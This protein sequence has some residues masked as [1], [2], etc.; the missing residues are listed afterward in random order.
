VRE[1]EEEKKGPFVSMTLKDFMGDSANFDPFS[2]DVTTSSSIKL[3][4]QQQ[5]QQQQQQQEQEQEQEQQQEQQLANRYKMLKMRKN[6]EQEIVKTEEF[7]VQSLNLCITRYVQPMNKDAKKVGLQTKLDLSSKMFSS[8]LVIAR[9]HNVLLPELKATAAEPNIGPDFFGTALVQVFEKFLDFLKL[10]STFINNYPKTIALLNSLRDNRKFQKFLEQTRSSDP[11]GQTLVS[12]LIMPVQRIPRYVLLFSELI[13]HTPTS[14]ASYNPARAVLAKLEA[15]AHM[16]NENK[17]RFENISKLADIQSLLNTTSFVVAT[18]HRRIIKQGSLTLVARDRPYRLFLFNDIVLRT[19]LA[20]NLKEH[21]KIVNMKVGNDVTSEP[22]KRALRFRILVVANNY[23][24]VQDL[25][26]L[27]A[28]NNA[29]R[30]EWYKA[31]ED[32]IVAA[33]KAMF[34]VNAPPP[35]S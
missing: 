34:S 20:Y 3:A 19:S 1:Q 33:Q 17:R 32:A 23:G 21:V 15:I 10:Y 7:Y 14:D 18:P 11:S 27:E 16:I 12:Y 5:Q 25:W 24:N 35:T 8:L 9:F 29:E 2:L 13:K 28:A 30:M 31:F 22:D 6:L 26:L 4:R